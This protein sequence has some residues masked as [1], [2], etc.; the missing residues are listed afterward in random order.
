MS[1]RYCIPG[2]SIVA[3]PAYAR[4]R[5]SSS[6]VPN[7]FSMITRTFASSSTTV[8]TETPLS[9]ATFMPISLPV[10]ML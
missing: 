2:Q 3:T 6:V 4:D 7:G 9:S 10:L 8:P 1:V 5:A